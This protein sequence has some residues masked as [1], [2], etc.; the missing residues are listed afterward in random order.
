MTP[1]VGEQFCECK[2]CHL[3][4]SSTESND[5]HTSDDGRRILR[6]TNTNVSDCADQASHNKEPAATKEISIR[7]H[8]HPADGDADNP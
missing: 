8:N 5:G 7:A 6:D 4:Q 1:L 2:G 3:A